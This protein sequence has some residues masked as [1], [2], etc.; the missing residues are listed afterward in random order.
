MSMCMGDWK[1]FDI[2]NSK[3]WVVAFMDDSSRL[4]TFSGIFDSPITQN[5][6]PVLNQ[7]FREYG[8]PRE[9][10]NNHCTQ[11]FSARDRDHAQHTFK[12]FLNQYEIKPIVTC[13]KHHQ[14]NGKIE[15]F[16]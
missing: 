9:I 7:G 3:K 13:E 4:I 15:W 5:P 10:L 6:I 8:T 11:F 16:F 12:N 14:T 1:K 2:D